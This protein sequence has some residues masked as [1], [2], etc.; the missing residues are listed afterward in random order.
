MGGSQLIPSL[1]R[2]LITAHNSLKKS[3]NQ[4]ELI[5]GPDNIGILFSQMSLNERFKIN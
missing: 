3:D 5:N 4:L 2:K 1:P